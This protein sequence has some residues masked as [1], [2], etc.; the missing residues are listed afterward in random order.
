MLTPL[1][2]FLHITVM[3][4]AIMVAYGSGLVLRV[5]YMTGQVA[6][7]RGAGAAAARLGPFI[8][9]LFISGGL[10]GLLTAISFGQDLT[11]PWLVIAYTLFIVA[12]GIGIVEN[13]P[14]GEH[15]GA[16]LAQTPDGPVTPEVR[17]MFTSTRVVG[18]T[19]I[20]YAIVIGI[21]FD[22]VVKPFS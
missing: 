17:A 22:M 12:M 6:A 15:L 19:I 11:A 20:E 1:L 5:A 14:W 13:R 4:V 3:F 21:I 16:L 8:P 7:I 9:I 10:L 18:V 2:L